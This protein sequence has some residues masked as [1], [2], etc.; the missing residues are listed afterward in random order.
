MR[1]SSPGRLRVL[2]CAYSCNRDDVGSAHT[3]YHWVKGLAGHCDITLLTRRRNREPCGAEAVPNVRTVQFDEWP[4]YS[5]FVRFDRKFQPGYFQFALQSFLW[6]RRV[7][8]RE[9]FDLVHQITPGALRYPSP[10][11]L[12]GVPFILGPAG[13]CQP[14]P[15]DLAPALRL[16]SLSEYLRRF[17]VLRMRLD[18]LMGGTLRGAARILVFGRYVLA[19]VPPAFRHKC[20]VFP[21]GG[22]ES[23]PPLPEREMGKARVDLLFVGRV[24]P[25]KGLRFLLEALGRV[26]PDVPWRLTVVGDGADLAFSKG[27]AR[28]L[29][30]TNRVRFV[31]K[32][33]RRQVDAFY[34]S[35]DIFCLPTIREGV[36]FAILEA[37]SYG[38]PVVVCDYA[39]PSETVGDDC[40][41][42]VPPAG[43]RT[44][45]ANIAKAI[46]MLAGSH[47]L[48]H[49]MGQ[50]GRRRVADEF[51]WPKRAIRMVGIY[52]EVLAGAKTGRG[53]DG[54]ARIE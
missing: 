44:F 4:F 14:T 52:R 31:G 32:V 7:V 20:Q 8:A 2:I 19:T 35:A 33:P 10:M 42:K 50:A 13:G 37:M 51:M 29:G 26:K 16:G 45:V 43:R 24:E 27:L 22:F 40:G 39:G 53:P 48:R 25:I 3:A 36:G 30:L 38:L 21:D 11:G 49:H 5:R 23:L 15:S 41:F 1:P 47:A 54:L 46:E 12:L 18:P 17:D 9:R 34:A 28:G 6:A